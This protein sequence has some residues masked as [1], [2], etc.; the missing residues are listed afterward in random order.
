MYLIPDPPESVPDPVT[1]YLFFPWN[2]MLVVCTV[3]D[4]LI[5][6]SVFHLFAQST[7]LSMSL[8]IN[9]HKKVRVK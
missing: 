1:D 9:A 8:K 7:E 3:Y 6:R 4:T 5:V 2:C